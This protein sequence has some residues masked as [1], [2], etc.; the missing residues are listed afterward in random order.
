MSPFLVLLL[1]NCFAS[2]IVAYDKIVF[3]QP[4]QIHLA[5]GGN[6]FNVDDMMLLLSYRLIFDLHSV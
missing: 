1:A 4:E 2:V 3:Y 6:V 5:L